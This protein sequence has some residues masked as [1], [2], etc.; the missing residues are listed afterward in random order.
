MLNWVSEYWYL[1][2]LALVIGLLTAAWVWLQLRPG[3]PQTDI[4]DVA[5]A[6]P[7]GRLEPNRPVID[8]AGPVEFTVPDTTPA[9]SPLTDPDHSN[10]PAVAAA[11]GPPDD[12]SKIKGIGPKLIALLGSLG[13]SRYDQIA[14]WSD[15]DIAEVDRFLGNFQGRIARDNWVDQA[16]LLADGDE[17]AFA[18]KYGSLGGN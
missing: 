15:A 4:D 17:A 10:R 3:R 8:V 13:I 12:L 18:A 5:P 9:A 1:C 7:A 6:E 2:L 14:A 16:R 11:S